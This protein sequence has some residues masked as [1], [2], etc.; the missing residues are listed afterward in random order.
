MWQIRHA[1]LHNLTMDELSIMLERHAQ[2][3]FRP[4]LGLGAH[5]FE[6]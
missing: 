4:D 3:I 6:G 2:I 1:A 5:L